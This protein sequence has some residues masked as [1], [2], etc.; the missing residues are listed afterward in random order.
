MPHK[1]NCTDKSELGIDTDGNDFCMSCGGTILPH[2]DQ[3]LIQELFLHNKLI[4][5][6]KLDKHLLKHDIDALLAFY[7]QHAE[8]REIEAS[9]LFPHLFT[10]IDL[11]NQDLKGS[12]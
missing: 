7:Y 6:K 11:L 10:F 5:I 12:K 8:D 1:P 9:K 3:F 2:E 4:A